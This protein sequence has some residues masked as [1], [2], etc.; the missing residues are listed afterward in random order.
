LRKR[1]L[2][3][4]RELVEGVLPFDRDL[5]R[6]NFE[7]ELEDNGLSPALIKERSAKVPAPFVVSTV[8][9]AVLFCKSQLFKLNMSL[10]SNYKPI[11]NTKFSA[12]NKFSIRVFIFRF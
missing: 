2:Y 9:L 10:F 3:P 4:V 6:A 8:I 7:K 5:T 12:I 11:D 1:G